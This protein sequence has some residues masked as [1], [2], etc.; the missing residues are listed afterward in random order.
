MSLLVTDT[1]LFQTRELACKLHRFDLP[2]TNGNKNACR[3]LIS[4]SDKSIT[5]ENGNFF[6][7]LLP[8]GVALLRAFVK[9]E[10]KF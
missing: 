2:E 7:H 10:T 9:S 5:M 1:R 3:Y 4:K 8:Q 6:A